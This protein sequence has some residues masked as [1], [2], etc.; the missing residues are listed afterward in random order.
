MKLLVVD[1][2]QLICDGLSII[3]NS[4][5]DIEVIG[6][7]KNGQE[8]FD[9]CKTYRPDI[10]LM[11]IRMPEVDGI[12]GVKM[13][14]KEFPEVRVLM[15]TTFQDDNYIK[16]AIKNG[17]QGYLL[18]NQ[19]A[20]VIIDSIKAAFKGSFIC[21]KGV[22]NSLKE[23]IG[24]SPYSEENLKKY[25]ISQREFQVLSLIAKGLNN[26]EISEQLFIGQGTVRNYVTSLLDKL[27]LRDRTQLALFYLKRNKD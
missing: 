3:M 1:D 22:L 27:E 19:G 12:K 16:E 17:A 2:D 5:E 7:A 6:I 25:G 13:I 26:K 18:K 21:E 11:D 8:A 24:D 23:M 20:D 9:M 14:K 4:E 15:L 10:V